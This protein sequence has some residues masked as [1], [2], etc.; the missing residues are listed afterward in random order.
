MCIFKALSTICWHNFTVYTSG[1]FKM[2][3]HCL[4]F[5]LDGMKSK[6]VSQ[7]SK[8]MFRTKITAKS[9]SHSNCFSPLLQKKAYNFGTKPFKRSLWYSLLDSISN[10]RYAK[11]YLIMSRNV[12]AEAFQALLNLKFSKTRNKPV[13]LK[14]NLSWISLKKND[15][16]ATSFSSQ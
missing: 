1:E 13:L 8:I 9:I 5:F 12:A 16:L 2:L 14:P 11:Y 6:N 15:N 4:S 3:G 7:S 10:F